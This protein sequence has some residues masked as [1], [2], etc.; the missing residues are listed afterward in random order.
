[1]PRPLLFQVVII[2]L[3]QEFSIV[4][5]DYVLPQ[6]RAKCTCGVLALKDLILSLSRY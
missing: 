2:H 6:S 5:S 4:R 3:F 1:M